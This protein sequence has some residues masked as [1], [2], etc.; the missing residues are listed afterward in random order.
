YCSSSLLFSIICLPPCSSLFPYT[1]LFRSDFL[2]E[3]RPSRCQKAARQFW[4]RIRQSLGS[5]LPC[6]RLAD[7]I[8]EVSYHAEMKMQESWVSWPVS[9]RT[10]NLVSPGKGGGAFNFFFM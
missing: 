2:D 1:T 10:S 3:L 9:G 8:R 4:L 6:Q 5:L 7:R